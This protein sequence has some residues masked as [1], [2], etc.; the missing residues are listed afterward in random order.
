MR[1]KVQT[2]EEFAAKLLGLQDKVDADTA[3]A[4]DADRLTVVLAELPL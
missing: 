1:L 4:A 3:C 2:P